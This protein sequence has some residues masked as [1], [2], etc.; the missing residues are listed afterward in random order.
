M[1]S[2][3]TLAVFL[4]AALLLV[5]A[6][7]GQTLEQNWNDFLHYTAIGR[8]DLAK[9]YA[10][11]ILQSNP[12]PVQLLALSKDNPEGYAILLKVRESAPDAELVA[13]SGKVL[14]IIERGQFVRRSDPK[15]IVE[16]IKRLRSTERGKLLA[17]ERLKNAGE[18]A[19]PYMLDAMADHARAE[20]LPNIVEA[21]P[22]IG[23]PAVRPLAAGLQTE[24]V[25]VKAEIIKALGKIA[26][27]Q[28]LGYLK[29]VIEKSDSPEMRQLAAESIKQI[30]P[31]A[32]AA[33]AAQLLFQLAEAYYD[34]SQSLAPAE[35]AN[36]ANIWFWD[37][38]QQRLARQEVDK[39]YFHELMAMRCC[40]WS[41][42][43]D[44]GFGWAIGLWL[45]AFFK[46]E[47]TGV[48]MPAYF[49]DRHADAL[50]YATTAGPEYLHQALA[51]AVKDK[52]PDVALGAVEALA[53]TAGEKSLYYTVGPV[54]PL[55]QA[56]SFDDRAVRYSAA[57]AIAAAGPQE[58]FAESTLVVNNLAEAL[59]QSA[60][61]ASPP[62]AA[63]PR[64]SQEL[65]GNYSL[66]AAEVMLKLA[67][68]RNPA[69]NLSAAQVALMNA[70]Q[71][72]RPEIQILA[73]QVLAH[74]VSPN[75]QRTIATMALD[76]GNDP[77][78]RIAAFDSLAA[79]AK[80]HANMLPDN[81]IGQIYALIS[82]DQTEP[83]LRAAAAAAYGALNLPSRKVKD[84]ILDQAKS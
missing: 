35:D 31:A 60:Q 3:K 77:N 49:G 18:Y 17:T 65:A 53:I 23:L 52:N 44:E 19:I 62:P 9:A 26:Y 41:L 83:D 4:A 72:K 40:E 68:T 10:Q 51:R 66:R 75:A 39:S 11:V 58:R 14:E 29:Y 45:A 20:E 56:L 76:G 63:T 12:D 79:S 2:K 32:I 61:Q 25:Q 34:H 64:W 81:I 27:P 73:G 70:T 54:Q 33:P 8:L 28:S 84:L 38:A 59:G 36:F 37:S 82:S 55:L 57:I 43:S 5:T 7:F 21:L 78:V 30:D 47:A 80:L 67:Q 46:A 48:K 24:N 15:I 6:G 1:L 42:K 69:I 16:E 13:L 22:Q 74:L 50:V 71:T